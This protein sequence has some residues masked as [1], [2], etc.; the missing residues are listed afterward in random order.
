[1]LNKGFEISKYF[2]GRFVGSLNDGD[3][4]MITADH[5]NDP[6]FKGTDHTREFVPL[7]SYLPGGEPRSLGI[8]NG[9]F[10]IAQSLASF[11]GIE[12]MERG[13]SFL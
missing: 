2:L 4:M 10:D 5:G 7:L 9:F 8:R 13:L 12:P 6:T 1:M 3:L 11:F